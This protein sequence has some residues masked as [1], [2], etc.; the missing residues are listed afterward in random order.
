MYYR[1]R[2]GV[3]LHVSSIPSRYGVGD[4]GPDA[5]RFVDF[6]ADAGLSIWQILP[7]NPTSHKFGNSPYHP[8]SSFG[9]NYIFVSP[10][11]LAE[12]GL[13]SKDTLDNFFR[14]PSRVVDYEF[15]YGFKRKVLMEAWNNFRD[16]CER[17]DR[18]KF[19]EF[20]HE[21]RWWLED[22]ALFQ[23]IRERTAKEWHQWNEDLK[24]RRF[25][26]SLRDELRNLI[27][28]FKF[29]QFVFFDQWQKL[30][31][32]ANSKG[33]I[34]FG[35]ISIYPSY[36]SMDVWCN[37]Q[38]FKLDERMCPRVVAGV[39]PDFFS[40]TGQLW[41]N[42]IYDWDRLEID[43]FDLW[44]RRLEFS[45][46]LYDILRLDH[47]RGFVAYWEVPFGESTAVKGRW[48]PAPAEK[49]FS[50]VIDRFG[51]ERIVVED[52]GFITDD[53]RYVRDRFGFAGM[54][55]LEFAFYDT[56][57]EHLPHNYTP[58]TVCYI[59]T[60]DNPPAKQWFRE[61]GDDVRKRFF[62]YVGR[63]L[64][65]DD[66]A[67]ELIRLAFSSVSKYAIIQMQD[68]IGDVGRM[69]RPST[70]EGN[71]LWRLESHSQYEDRVQK[72]ARLVEIYGRG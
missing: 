57:S 10:E 58:N 9:G 67:D 16:S 18:V 27:D 20:C 56:N 55:V 46:R 30:K 38:F 3:L 32:Y 60:H 34:I 71:W 44:M 24:F 2:A 42:P 70:V 66:V 29:E 25:S 4:F 48:V 15:S 64:S 31:G 51:R 11:K 5:Y 59:G 28:F 49:F 62:A 6:L 43:G 47:F 8:L 36:D 12:R 17:A 23:S 69:N 65:E 21:N 61:I 35:D 63:E 45:L 40:E 26:E 1:R 54:R 39:P 33:I 13:I 7:L 53:V 68:F 14:P 37:P 52:L 72:I 41:G 19:E 22:Y 50:K